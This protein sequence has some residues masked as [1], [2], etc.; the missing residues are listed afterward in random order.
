MNLSFFS[1]ILI[2]LGIG[3]FTVFVID[4]L[5]PS[6]VSTPFCLGIVLMGLS[7]RQS[8]ELV[9]IVSLMYAILT[10]YALVSFHNYYAAH[11]HANPYPFFWLFQ[12]VGLFLVLCMLAIYLSHYRTDTQRILTRFQT[13]LSKLPAP[14]I[15]SDVSGTITYANDTVTSVFHH[16]P[17]YLIG[18]SYFDFVLTESMKGK[19]IR[20]YFDLI[21]SDTNG[22]CDLETSPFGPENKRTAQIICLGT[23]QNRIMITPSPEY[24]FGLEPVGFSAAGEVAADEIHRRIS[25]VL[26]PFPE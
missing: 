14:V 7:L 4:P 8:T 13:I 21:E 11:V 26:I 24:R 25:K 16:P 5:D 19:S 17:S 18:R 22:I 2:A 3:L 1:K 10:I 6:T 9:V 15:I 12:R 23:G 20:S